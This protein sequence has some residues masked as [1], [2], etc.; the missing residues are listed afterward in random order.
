MK[1]DNFFTDL[2]AITLT[3]QYTKRAEKLSLLIQISQRL[4][5]LKY[6]ITIL[7][8]AEGIDTTKYTQLAQKLTSIGNMLGRWMQSIPKKETP[9]VQGGE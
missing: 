5:Y 2:I 9:P 6:F 4:D 8:E 7:W 3:A 1:I